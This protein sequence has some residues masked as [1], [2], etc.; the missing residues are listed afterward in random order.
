MRF[1]PAS[2]SQIN[3]LAAVAGLVLIGASAA[4]VAVRTVQ[5]MGL[6][7]RYYLSGMSEPAAR[8][9][10]TTIDERPDTTALRSHVAEVSFDRFTAVWE[11]FLVAPRSGAHRFELES[12]DGSRLY[13]DG[14]IAIDNWGQHEARTVKRALP[15]SKGTHRIRIEYEQIFGEAVLQVRWDGHR[16]GEVRPLAPRD[17]STRQPLPI[18][19]QVRPVLAPSGP[20]L[21][22]IWSGVVISLLFVPALL[23]LIRHLEQD[24][25]PRRLLAAVVGLGLVVNATGSWWGLPPWGWLAW[26]PDEVLPGDVIRA[27]DVRFANGWHGAYPPGHYYL[28]GWLFGPVLFGARLGLVEAAMP[29]SS[30]YLALFVIARLTTVLMASLTVVLVH[31]IGQEI[32]GPRA[33]AFA[34]FVTAFAIPIGFYSK[35]TNLD[36]PYLFWFAL[37]FWFYARAVL[38]RGRSN[39]YGYALAATL[40][41]CTKD[42]AYA[43]YLLPSLHLLL[44]AWRSGA[45]GSRVAAIWRWLAGPLFA[46]VVLFGVVQNF[47]FNFDGFVSHVR[48]VSGPQS[49]NFRMFEPTAAGQLQLFL[50]ALPQF[51]WMFG[52]AGLGLIAIGLLA[53]ATRGRGRRRWWIFLPS[54]SYYLTFIAVIGYHY[55]RF[56]L[57]LVVAFALTIGVALDRLLRPGGFVPAR[58]AAVGAMALIAWRGLSADAMMFIESRYAAERWLRANVGLRVP[59]YYLGG[60]GYL[61]RFDGVDAR[62]LDPS[63]PTPP[64]ALPPVIVVNVEYMQRYDEHR[65][66]ARWWKWL[67]GAT[68]PYHVAYRIKQR[69]WWSAMSYESRLYT[70]VEDR[71]SNFGKVNPDIAVFMPASAVSGLAAPAPG[72]PGAR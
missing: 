57:P 58:F 62:Q 50:D 34:A 2:R 32:Y 72:T 59:V 45:G 70:G 25:G 18:L 44:V 28:L 40:S 61:P 53:L 33:G 48:V 8:P 68:S 56:W 17:L 43:L 22:S 5:P 51:R 11:G 55:D 67:S 52:W 29:P 63:I 16:E 20:L 60:L 69:P 39:V 13:L 27:I 38:G 36:L 12:D 37:S 15:L 54:A 71:Y 41:I 7:G 24:P 47:A 65:D 64:P 21:T 10:L 1:G 3:V 66:E 35:V 30:T 31:L 26:A 46:A 23:L 14:V 4:A 6:L 49:G 19:W 9:V 42:Q